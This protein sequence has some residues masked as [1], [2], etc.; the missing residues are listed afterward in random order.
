LDAERRL[1]ELL[2]ALAD[3]RL[4]RSAH[5]LS[6]GGLA[7]ALAECCFDT[8]GVGASVALTSTS[9]VPQDA[10]AASLLFGESAS[11]ALIS[12][13]PASAEDVLAWAAKSGVPARLLGR[14]GGASVRVE[15]DGRVALDVSVSDA[16][17][18]WSTAIERHFAKRVA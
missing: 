11:R 18:V 10:A 3:A 7:V 12:A 16:E 9:M 15:I 4:L 13:A 14:T 6:D 2:V 1:Q 8:G 5:D 17:R